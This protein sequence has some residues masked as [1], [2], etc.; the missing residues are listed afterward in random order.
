MGWSVGQY[1]RRR[2][3]DH[4]VEVLFIRA[5]RHRHDQF[6]GLGLA[7]RRERAGARIH[8]IGVDIAVLR[9]RHVDECLGG[10]DRGSSDCK[11]QRER[12]A[13][14]STP[15]CFH[16]SPSR[17]SSGALALM[18]P[19]AGIVGCCVRAESGHT[20]AA[21]P[22]TAMKSRH[23]LPSLWSLLTRPNAVRKITTPV[24]GRI[25][26]ETRSE[27]QTMAASV[28]GRG[29]GLEQDRRPYLSKPT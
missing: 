3:A 18:N 25:A 17:Q 22:R 10:A 24:A 20:P 1:A 11:Q 5:H 9:I 15:W 28:N 23:L 12:E 29:S 8:G 27:P 4:G 16:F 19:I 26:I 21:P 6:A 14:R 2:R 7:N 13:P